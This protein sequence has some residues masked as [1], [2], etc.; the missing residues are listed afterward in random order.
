MM[1]SIFDYSFVERT[2]T[3]QAVQFGLE[4]R[5]TSHSGSSLAVTQQLPADLSVGSQD[6]TPNM[7]PNIRCHNYAN[8]L[9]D[10][11]MEATVFVAEVRGETFMLFR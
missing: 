4:P 7:T 8:L 6:L 11:G 2:R 10:H 9:A 5:V 3:R 1:S